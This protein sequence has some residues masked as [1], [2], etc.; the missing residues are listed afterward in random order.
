MAETEY[1]EALAWLYALEAARGMDFKLERVALALK[2]LGDPQAR[3]PCIHVAGTNGKGSVSAMMH[4]VFGAAGYRTGLYTSP[5]LVSFPERICVGSTLVAEDK[6]VEL[7]RR[8]RTAATVRGID[9]TFFEFVTVMAFLHFADEAVDVA[10]IEVGLGG[11]LDATNVITPLVSVITSV[12]LDHEEYLGTR[13]GAIAAEKG[14]IIKPGVPVVLGRIGSEA[15]AV[16]D[17]AA[18]HHRAR[19]WR[20]IDDFRLSGAENATFV[21]VGSN[22]DG[23]S[24]ALRG[25]FQI[26]NAELAIAAIRLTAETLP[27]DDDAIRLGLSTVQWPGRLEV[28]AGE[29]MVIVDGAHNTAAIRRLTVELPEIAG[30]RRIHLLF[31]VMRDKKW[32]SMIELLMPYVSTVTVTTALPGRGE[33]PV[34]L[35]AA[36]RYR[37]PVTVNSDPVAAFE[38][39]LSA[40]GNGS[41]ILVTGSLFLVGHVYPAFVRRR[42][43]LHTHALPE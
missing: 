42:Q 40:A 10:V 32:E 35:A 33:D 16:I 20:A 30:D 22:L 7:V 28:L 14:G 6:I 41:A 36:A 4:A 37:A 11:R 15:G 34:R 18:A 5:H 43:Q 19:V 17:E 29:P 8:I 12:D 24:F 9:L 13:V 38:G 39:L 27:V 25:R 2:N 21:G 3:Y 23:I 26:D 31:A 1:A